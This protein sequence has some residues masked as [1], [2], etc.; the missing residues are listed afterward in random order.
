MSARRE[1]STL[2]PIPRLFKVLAVLTVCM[3]L[4]YPCLEAL[5]TTAI[6]GANFEFEVLTALFVLGVFVTLIRLVLLAITLLLLSHAKGLT[7]EGIC[8]REFRRISPFVSP[9]G[10]VPL[11]I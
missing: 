6:T 4:V 1:M 9:P 11:R 5:D 3:A 10:L 7:A 2:R 8:F